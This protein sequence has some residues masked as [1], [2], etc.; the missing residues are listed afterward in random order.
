MRTL[1]VFILLLAL[2]A[3]GQGNAVLDDG[4]EG[5]AAGGEGGPVVVGTV[6]ALTA[7]AAEVAPEARVELLAAHG[8]DPHDLELSPGDRSL[9]TTADVVLYPGDLD[10]QP[11]VEAAV[12]EATGEVV[13]V[14]D[15]VAADRL[16]TL[17]GGAID[18]HLWFDAKAMAQTAE[19][20]GAALARVQPE[21]AEEHR[22]SAAAVSAELE[23]LSEE[24]DQ[25]LS[26]CE[27]D[28]AIVSHEAYAY[29]VEPRG[30]AQEGI[31]GG[32]GHSGVSPQRLSE[33]TERI[34]D[35][36]I[37]AVLAEPVEGREDAESLAREAG[38]DLLDIDP[39]E[40]SAPGG[41]GA[42]ADLLRA[43]A[44]AFAIALGCG[45]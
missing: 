24:L 35:E 33:L 8:Q 15:V 26:D 34:R 27:R 40:S 30:L 41:G 36:G 12:A 7:I 19:A 13:A 45:R 38:V 21:A 10:F 2:A 44:E 32:A 39:L 11:Q 18:P 42:F 20:I 14:A 37:P 16:L 4:G 3:C 5:A 31:A 17:D 1:P 22:S 43:Q 25:L 9:L 29:L 28:T 23:A 6:Y